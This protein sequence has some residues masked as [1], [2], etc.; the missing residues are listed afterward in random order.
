[1]AAI[2][3]AAFEL[4]EHPPCSP[5]LGSSDFYVFSRLKEHL[6]GH[7]FEDDDAIVAAVDGFLRVQEVCF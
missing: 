6:R 3:E 1:M 5:D 2:Q 7:K 4:M